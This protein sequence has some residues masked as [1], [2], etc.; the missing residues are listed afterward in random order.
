MMNLV[1]RE[2][3]FENIRKVLQCQKAELSHTV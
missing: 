2:P 1:H 3:D